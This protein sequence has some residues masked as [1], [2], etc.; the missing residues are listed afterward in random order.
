MIGPVDR[1]SCFMQMETYTKGSGRMIKLT[2]LVLTSTPTGQSKFFFKIL[3]FVFFHFLSFRY[4]GE[5]QED[6]QSGYGKEIWPDGAKFEGDY[7]DG[8]K[9][10]KG[11]LTFADNA[12]YE[13]EFYNNDIEGTGLYQWNDKR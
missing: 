13:G 3:K 5:W 6:R 12:F 4:E 8:L 10:G 7:V 2:A 9:H 11:K 1:A